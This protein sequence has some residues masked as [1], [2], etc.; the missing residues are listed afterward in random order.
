VCR[1]IGNGRE[2]SPPMAYRVWRLMPMRRAYRLQWYKQQEDEECRA[3]GMRGPRS[4]GCVGLYLIF[5]AGVFYVPGA[6]R[7]RGR[8]GVLTPIV[9]MAGCADA[10]AGAIAP[11]SVTFA[12]FTFRAYQLRLR[13]LSKTDSR[14]PERGFSANFTRL[15]DSQ[16]PHN[17]DAGY[18]SFPELVQLG[19]LSE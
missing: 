14:M 13:K 9:I 17:R 19:V 18:V 1:A 10:D 4:P 12:Q 6:D 15:F 8:P 11:L 7:G 3:S 16:E 5:Q 2:K